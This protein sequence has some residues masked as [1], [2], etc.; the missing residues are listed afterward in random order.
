[1]STPPSDQ[2]QFLEVPHNEIVEKLFA[3]Q[4]EEAAQIMENHIEHAYRAI[5]GSFVV[6]Q[7]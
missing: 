2:A 4:T 1:M 5:V 6:L 7:K 3:G